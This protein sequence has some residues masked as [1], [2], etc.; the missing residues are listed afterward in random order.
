MLLNIGSYV[1]TN[2]FFF[3]AKM[4]RVSKIFNFIYKNEE[5]VNF[6]SEKDLGEK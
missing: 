2:L 4:R 5:V 3:M 6:L 1:D